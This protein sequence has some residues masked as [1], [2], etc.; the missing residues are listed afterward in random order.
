MQLDTE[1]EE[2][3]FER[4]RVEELQLLKGELCRKREKTCLPVKVKPG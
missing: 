1:W 4:P 2:D 3:R